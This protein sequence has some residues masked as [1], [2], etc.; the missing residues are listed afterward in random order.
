MGLEFLFDV[1]PF[2]IKCGDE[3]AVFFFVVV[4]FEFEEC[5]VGDHEF[6]VDDEECVFVVFCDVFAFVHV[7]DGVGVWL[8]EVFDEVEEW[9]DAFC[10]A[11]ADACEEVVVV[12][13]AAYVEF[14]VK[15]CEFWEFV[16]F[17]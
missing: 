17:F 12:F 16:L 11:F 2:W 6:A 9:F 3:V 5:S 13:Y 4:E 1:E 14:F 8:E 15:F 7:C 10:D